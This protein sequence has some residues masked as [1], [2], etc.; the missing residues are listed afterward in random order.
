MRKGSHSQRDDQFYEES[1]DSLTFY[2]DAG[3]TVP[4]FG[5]EIGRAHV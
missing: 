5:I 2:N 4:A 3:E 1:P